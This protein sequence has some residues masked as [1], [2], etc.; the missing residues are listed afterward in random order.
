M[1]PTFEMLAMLRKQIGCKVIYYPR[2]ERNPTIGQFTGLDYNEEKKIVTITLQIIDRKLNL[3]E[4]IDWLE[5]KIV[6][7]NVEIFKFREWRVVFIEAG[8]KVDME[9]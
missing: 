4:P 6:S 9:G 8:E 7:G 5:L 2:P 3:I 1:K